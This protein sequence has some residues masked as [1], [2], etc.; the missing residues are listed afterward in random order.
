MAINI[1]FIIASFL[2][3]VLISHSAVIYSEAISGNLSNNSNLPTVITTELLL[4]ENTVS[5]TINNPT[6]PTFQPDVFTFTVPEGY[7]FTNLVINLT[8][9]TDISNSVH[10]LGLRDSTSS[11]NV[12]SDTLFAT[13]V[14]SNQN[15]TVNILENER[16]GGIA[17]PASD[18]DFP[19]GYNLPLPADDYTLWFQET[20]NTVIDYTFTLTLSQVPEPSSAFLFIGAVS[21]LTFRRN[22]KSSH[23]CHTI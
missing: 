1:Q 15:N 12:T 18:P 23:N 17:L 4:G 22:R 19:L 21:L 16:N 8:S 13:L 7:V 2:S 9:T 6:F 11:F 10:F 20:D 3:S 14:S 5:G